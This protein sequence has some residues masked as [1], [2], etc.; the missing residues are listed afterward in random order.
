MILPQSYPAVLFLMVLSLLCLGSWASFFKLAGKWRF[1]LFYL[2]FA[3]GL[4]LA[5]VIFAFTV[6]NIGYDGFNFIDDLQHAGKRQWMYV[7]IAGLIFNLGNMLLMGAVSVAGLAVAFPMGMGVALLAGSGL[8]ISS[9]PAVNAT[10]LGLGCLLILT[11]IVVNAVSYRIMGVA[12]HEALARAGKAKS[13]RRPSPLKGIVLAV[14]AGLLIGG[15]TPIV[16]KARQGDLGMGP[17]SLGFIFAFGVFFSSFVFDI[18]FMNL[19]VEGD[20]VEF[21]WYLNGGLKQHLSGF[22]SGFVWYTGMVSA[23]VCTSVPEAMQGE[24]LP[25]FLLAQGSPVLAALWGILVF[26][27]FKNSDIRVKLL[28]T[29]MLVLFLCGLCMIGLAPLLL[30]KD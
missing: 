1:E 22:V 11:S 7:F 2:D 16:E 12:R 8:G 5:S 3:I 24:P 23:W 9:R 21:G 13:T 14:L 10:L 30:R 6:G 20:P 27:E 4:L 18:F 29:L 17:Y 15:F 26:R 25:R 19:P 28:G